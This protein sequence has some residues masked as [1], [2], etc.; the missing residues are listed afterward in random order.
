MSDDVLY[1]DSP[2]YPW[3]DMPDWVPPLVQEQVRL[4]W[5]EY[6]YARPDAASLA[7]RLAT[8]PRMK[9]AWGQLRK[10]R[11]RS[12]VYL[13]PAEPTFRS[14]DDI[15][16]S[17]N[18]GHFM[19]A[20][21]SG[22]ILRSLLFGSDQAS[23]HEQSLWLLYSRAFELSYFRKPELLTRLE[24][25]SRAEP[26][27]ELAPYLERAADL[28]KKHNRSRSEQVM[29]RE[30]AER[31]RQTS[32]NS[33]RPNTFFSSSKKG[34]PRLR[35]FVMAL[36]EESDRLIGSSPRGTIAHFAS[37]VFEKD[38]SDDLVGSILKSRLYSVD[39]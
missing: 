2:A 23:L 29:L 15:E 31:F 7:L 11:S 37:T 3:P 19:A 28:L 39:F 5:H 1:L 21:K 18:L 6:S 12:K 38:V 4:I 36:S 20:R 34:S 8:A 10:K 22:S 14:P 26:F 9:I 30:L 24:A 35:A 27:L 16:A 25:K 17:S 33:W 32:Y 13:Y